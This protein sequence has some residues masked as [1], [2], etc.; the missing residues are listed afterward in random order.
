M[1]KHFFRDY[2][3]V[4]Y[5]QYS[6]IFNNRINNSKNLSCNFRQDQNNPYVWIHTLSEKVLGPR[7][8]TP[9]ILPKKA[10]LDPSGINSH[11]NHMPGAPFMEY[12]PT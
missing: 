9:V 6:T 4:T 12:F 1:S 3:T 10:L 2:S 7:N 8:Q 5:Q 11:L